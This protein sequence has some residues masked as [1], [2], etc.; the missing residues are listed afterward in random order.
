MNARFFSKKKILALGP[1]WK[2]RKEQGWQ[3]EEEALYFGK[4]GPSHED[5]RPF[6]AFPYL[7][8]VHYESTTIRKSLL[9]EISTRIK[10]TKINSLIYK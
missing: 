8:D 5:L 6:Y 7:N 10:V 2:A 3:V 9:D 4:L 1:F